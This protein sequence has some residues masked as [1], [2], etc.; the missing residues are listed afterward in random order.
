MAEQLQIPTADQIQQDQQEQYTTMKARHDEWEQFIEGG[1]ED[2]ELA[3][4]HLFVLGH[5]QPS[6]AKIWVWKLR[7]S[8]TIP[9]M[10]LRTWL[11]KHGHHYWKEI[12]LEVKGD[13]GKRSEL[14]EQVAALLPARQG[15]AADE[16]ME[17]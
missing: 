11:L 12:G 9:G 2:V 1:A 5:K 7:V 16:S 3:I 14:E 4:Q 17:A 13:R 8:H 15:P 6:S 10:K